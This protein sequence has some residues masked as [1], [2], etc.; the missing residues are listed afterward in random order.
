[1]T[2]LLLVAALTMRTCES[3]IGACFR[4]PQTAVIKHFSFLDSARLRSRAIRGHCL[5]IQ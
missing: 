4:R 3:G 2:R 5:K 1:M